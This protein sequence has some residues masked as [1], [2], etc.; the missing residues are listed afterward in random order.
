MNMTVFKSYYGLEL[1]VVMKSVV[2]DVDHYYCCCCYCLESL[3]CMNGIPFCCLFIV[4][5]VAQDLCI[6]LQ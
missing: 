1:F 6:V 5:G 2:E 4:F 3:Q